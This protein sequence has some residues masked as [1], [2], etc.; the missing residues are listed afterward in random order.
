[1][2]AYAQ[3]LGFVRGLPPQHATDTDHQHILYC[4]KS[5]RERDWIPLAPGTRAPLGHPQGAQAA[6]AITAVTIRDTTDRQGGK[7]RQ[8]IC[9]VW[10]CQHSDHIDVNAT[11]ERIAALAATLGYVQTPHGTCCS[12]T[13]AKQIG[14]SIAAGRQDPQGC[15]TVEFK[16]EIAASAAPT[17]E[18]VPGPA[19]APAAPAIPPASVIARQSRSA[20]RGAAAQR[21]E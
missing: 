21:G 7:H 3:N 6:P 14:R 2:P 8:I 17:P 10:D 20:A 11:P 1:M 4:S 19:A 5:C 13:C 16:P 9:A 18:R 15:A 12:A